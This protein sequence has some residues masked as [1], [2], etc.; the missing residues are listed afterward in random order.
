MLCQ[1]DSD[2][3]NA[4]EAY[5]SETP[6]LTDPTFTELA[7]RILLHLDIQQPRNAAEACW[8]Y[9]GIVQALELMS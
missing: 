9:F 3:L 2:L 4:L 6:T 5:V 8:A 1:V 7:D